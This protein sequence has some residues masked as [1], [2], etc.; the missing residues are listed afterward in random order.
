[1]TVEEHRGLAEVL[2]GPRPCRVVGPR[3]TEYDEWYAMGTG[4][5][6]T[7]SVRLDKGRS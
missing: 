3:V 4:R 7:V 2:G 6:G 1:M 5:V